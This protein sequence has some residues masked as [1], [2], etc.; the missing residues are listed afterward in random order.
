MPRDRDAVVLEYPKRVRFGE[1]V[2]KPVEPARGRIG[3]RC[4]VDRHRCGEQV[5]LGGAAALRKQVERAGDATHARVKRQ[6]DRLEIGAGALR[7][8]WIGVEKDRLEAAIGDLLE[9]SPLAGKPS[10]R[11]ERA[12]HYDRVDFVGGTE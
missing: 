10:V 11:G 3:S 6:A 12:R 2:P 4:E 9:P 1:S 8:Q 5:V 7:G